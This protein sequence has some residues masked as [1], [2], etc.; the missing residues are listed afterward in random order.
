[1]RIWSD[2]RLGCKG[3]LASVLD[4]PA[5]ERHCFWSTSIFLARGFLRHLQILKSIHE[6]F[7]DVLQAS[8]GFNPGHTSN[9]THKPTIIPGGGMDSDR[10]MTNKVANNEPSRNATGATVVPPTAPTYQVP[11]ITVSSAEKGTLW[12]EPQVGDSQETEPESAHHFSFSARV[13]APSP[14]HPPTPLCR[15]C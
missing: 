7:I 15:V 9:T 8:R 11:T 2:C 1:V 14:K 6:L 4:Y 12:Q 5:T 3:G 10:R 13:L